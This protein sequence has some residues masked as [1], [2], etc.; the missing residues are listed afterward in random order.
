MRRILTKKSQRAFARSGTSI[1]PCCDTRRLLVE[2]HIGG[3]DIPDW[4]KP[5]NR[6]YICAGCHDDV[7]SGRLVIEGYETTTKGKK[8]IW[9]RKDS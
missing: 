1:C 5:W 3:R 7:H 9:H 8:L 6:A 4:D 2:H